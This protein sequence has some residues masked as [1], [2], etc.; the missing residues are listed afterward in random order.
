MYAVFMLGQQR[1]ITLPNISFHLKDLFHGTKVLFLLPSVGF[2]VW[3]HIMPQWDHRLTNSC[4]Q[5]GNNASVR[6]FLHPFVINGRRK[7]SNTNTRRDKSVSALLLTKNR[8]T[9]YTAQRLGIHY[10]LVDVD[11]KRKGIR[12]DWSPLLLPP[13]GPLLHPIHCPSVLLLLLDGA[14]SQHGPKLLRR[15]YFQKRKENILQGLPSKLKVPKTQKPSTT[16]CTGQLKIFKPVTPF[17]MCETV[18]TTLF[19]R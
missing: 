14:T 6:K 8:T 10:T 7:S 17:P 9:N 12:V 5:M 2:F 13:R 4:P 1:V 19:E 15:K 3:S 18:Q 16:Q 11:S